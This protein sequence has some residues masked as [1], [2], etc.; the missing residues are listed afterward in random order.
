[1][2]T[3]KIKKTENSAKIRKNYKNDFER[4]WEQ[5]IVPQYQKVIKMILEGL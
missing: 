3:L 4:L 2:E 5:K 1:M